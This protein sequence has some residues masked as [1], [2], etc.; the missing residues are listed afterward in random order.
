MLPA[1]TTNLLRRSGV[2]LEPSHNNHPAGIEITEPDHI[3]ITPLGRIFDRLFD[4]KA[5]VAT[6][7]ELVPL[8]AVGAVIVPDTLRLPLDTLPDTESEVSSPTVVMLGC[9][10]VVS[11]PDTLPDTDSD[12]SVPTLVMLGCAAVASV[13]DIAPATVKDV[14]VPTLVILGCAAVVK[15]PDMAPDTAKDVSVP[16][17]VMLGCAAVTSV[18]DTVPA[19]TRLLKVPND[20]ILG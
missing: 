1:P 7:V 13:P 3:T 9:E 17:L 14:S 2:P 18:P 11:V 16:T 19:T 6:C 20:V 10:G 5:V 4:T 15:V 8:A 12:V